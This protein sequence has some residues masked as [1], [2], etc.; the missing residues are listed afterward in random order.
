MGPAPA[1]FQHLS[2]LPAVATT[3]HLIYLIFKAQGSNASQL[4]S[5]LGRTLPSPKCI[6][7]INKVFTGTPG[8]FDQYSQLGASTKN[9]EMAML[10]TKKKIKKKI[11]ED[12]R[13]RGKN[14][15][16]S[17]SLAS[18]TQKQLSSKIHFSH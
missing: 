6:L 9:F 5:Q 8:I 4:S 11:L 13:R 2:F 10:G 14:K 15:E 3:E 7:S 12:F 18:H 1:H 17:R 16:I